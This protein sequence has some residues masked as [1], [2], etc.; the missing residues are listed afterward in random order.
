VFGH[1]I[2]THGRIDGN[3]SAELQELREAFLI[4]NQGLRQVVE[5]LNLQNAMLR[6]ILEAVSTEPS[7]ESPLAAL[8][9][10]LVTVADQHTEVLTDI[11]NGVHRLE[12][13]SERS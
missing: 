4:Q 6:Q 1:V 2:V 5:S 9:R 10:Q 13:S 8:L 12:H 11:A 3:R 7:E